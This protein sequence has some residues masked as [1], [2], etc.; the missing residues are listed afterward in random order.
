MPWPIRAAGTSME[1]RHSVAPIRNPI[2][3]YRFAAS[4]RGSRQQHG[5]DLFRNVSYPFCNRNPS[6]IR[7]SPP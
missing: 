3:R 1:R 7:K 6:E 5:D 4:S 2:H